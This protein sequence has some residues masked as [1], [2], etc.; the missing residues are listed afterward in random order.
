MKRISTIAVLGL[1]FS[2][3][4]GCGSNTVKGPFFEMKIPKGMYQVDVPD[5]FSYQIVLMPDS[6]KIE[7]INDMTGKVAFC[8]LKWFKG[9][10]KKGITKGLGTGTLPPYAEN[11]SGD[12]TKIG[13]M[14]AFSEQIN[15]KDKGGAQVIRS[16]F[17]TVFPFDGWCFEIIASVQ[18]GSS[19]DM[20]EVKKAIKE[21]EFTDASFAP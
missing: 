7:S 12:E 20:E 8:S 18:P 13:K 10:F 4:A 5:G 1:V 6:E 2:F 11:I 16:I 15:Q 3:L 9:A 14:T 19:V 17:R 21:I